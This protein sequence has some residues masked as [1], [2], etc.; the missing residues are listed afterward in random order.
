MS[1]SI[2]QIEKIYNTK[3]IRIGAQRY[4]RKFYESLGF[5]STNEF[6]M[7]DGIPHLYMIKTSK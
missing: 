5:I 4:L 2:E 3:T 6:Y 1:K 7:E